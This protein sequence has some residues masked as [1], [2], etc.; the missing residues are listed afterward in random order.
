MFLTPH[1]LLHAG[2]SLPPQKYMSFPPDSRTNESDFGLPGPSQVG[3][4]GEGP[5]GM[6]MISPKG[7]EKMTWALEKIIMSKSMV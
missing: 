6:G 3:G 5:A 2:Q 7:K 1:A 4:C